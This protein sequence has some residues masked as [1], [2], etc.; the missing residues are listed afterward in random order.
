MKT[1]SFIKKKKKKK[2]K[3]N[4]KNYDFL[5]KPAALRSGGEKEK[6]KIFHGKK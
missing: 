5:R 3:K 4:S 1:T 2:K 6:E